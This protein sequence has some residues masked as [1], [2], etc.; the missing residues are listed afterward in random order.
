MKPTTFEVIDP[1]TGKKKRCVALI[2]KLT[3]AECFKL[4]GL[5]DKEIDGIKSSGVSRSAQYKL[6]GNSIVKT[7]L[8]SLFDKA[9]IHTDNEPDE[10]G[11]MSLF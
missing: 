8:V 10:N 2:R 9:F 4:M 11:Q 6:A 1:K 7:V 5:N 3:E